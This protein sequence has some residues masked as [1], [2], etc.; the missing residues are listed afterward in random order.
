MNTHPVHKA[1]AKGALEFL[2]NGATAAVLATALLAFTTWGCGS[3]APRFRTGTVDVPGMAA[4]HKSAASHV[5]A[6]L[7]PAGINRDKV[8]LD[9]VGYIG[10]PYEYGGTTK[11]GID[12]SGFTQRVF[13][14]A[15]RLKL[16][17]S[18]AEQFRTG[19]PVPA[20]SLMF[21]DLV[22]FNTTGVTPSHVGIYIEDDVFAHASVINGVT[23]SSLEAE[24]YRERLVGARRMVP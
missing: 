16:P 8:L 7:T 2:Q 10:V 3:S 5:Y 22:F 11:E 4:E 9:L 12:C 21:G 20:D 19:R 13:L 18:T 15:L 6:N 24:Y 1:S 23:F 17:R 14:N